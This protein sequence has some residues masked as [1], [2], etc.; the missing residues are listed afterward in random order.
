[1]KLFILNIGDLPS[2]YY[3]AG[4]LSQDSWDRLLVEAQ[5]VYDTANENDAF[6]IN[7]ILDVFKVSYLKLVSVASEDTIS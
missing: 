7:D 2:T 6:S 5:A 4:T 1:M 3:F